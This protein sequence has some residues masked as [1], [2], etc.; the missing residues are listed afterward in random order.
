MGEMIFRFRGKKCRNRIF[1]PL[2]RVIVKNG[3]VL[4]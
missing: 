2:G 1:L 3:V 4:I